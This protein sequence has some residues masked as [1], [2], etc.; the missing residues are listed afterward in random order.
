MTLLDEL[1]AQAKS[2]GNNR[3]SKITVFL[4]KLSDKDR[5]EWIQVFISPDHSCRAIMEV[6]R[7]RG[8]DT[9]ISSIQATRVRLRESSSVAKK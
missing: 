5:K 9:S 1:R 6:L 8:V 4:E 2:H 7:K 3:R